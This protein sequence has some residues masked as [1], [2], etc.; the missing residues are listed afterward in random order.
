MNDWKEYEDDQVLFI[1]AGYIAIN[2]QDRPAAIHLLKAA[3]SLDPQSIFPKIGFG[4]YHLRELEVKEAL[5]FFREAVDLDPQSEM[6]Q[7]FLGIATSLIPS[8]SEVGESILQ[9][10]HKS[11]NP[12]I[13]TLADSALDFVE[14]HIKKPPGPAGS[15]KKKK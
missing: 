14:K 1:E 10:A 9:D 13:Q 5:P 2:Q 3:E 11:K 8:E 12:E 6:A 7:T 15:S 4:F